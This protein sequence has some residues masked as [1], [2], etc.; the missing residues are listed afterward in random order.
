VLALGHLSL[1]ADFSNQQYCF[2]YYMSA[3]S[4]IPN[5]FFLYSSPLLLTILI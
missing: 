1:W 3:M 5:A 4:I 2:L